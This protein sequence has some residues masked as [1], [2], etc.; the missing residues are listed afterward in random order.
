MRKRTLSVVNRS[1]RLNINFNSNT[2]I[3]QNQLFSLV[4]I[5]YGTD[6]EIT[7]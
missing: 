3:V 1:N 4:S 6:Q 5:K 7:E 2:N